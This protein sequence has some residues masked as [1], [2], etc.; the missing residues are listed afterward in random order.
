MKPSWTDAE[1]RETRKAGQ[2]PRR[3]PGSIR[4]RLLRAFLLIVIVAVVIL[5]FASIAVSLGSA[6]RQILDKLESVATLKQAEIELWL[7]GLRIDLKGMSRTVDMAAFLRPEPSGRA[8]PGEAPFEGLRDYMR[9]A[10]LFDEVFLMDGG[11]R[12]VA[13]TNPEQAGK[14]NKRQSYF[15]KGLEGP[16]FC[17]P[18]YYPPLDRM[19]IVASLPVTDGRGAVLGVLAG[20][21]SIGA[22]ERILSERAG[23][24]TS[25]ETYLIGANRVLLAESRPFDAERGMIARSEAANAAIGL[26]QDGS[27]LY[28]SHR[29]RA[30]AGAYRWMEGIQTALLVEQ[31][32]SEAFDPLYAIALVDSGIGL[33]TALAAFVASMLV[34]RNIA[35][36]LAE[37][38][39]TASR[40]AAG[41][42]DLPIP[43]ERDDE[44]GALASAFG[45]MA[46][47]LRKTIGGL[48]LRIE[49]RTADLEHHLGYLV[50]AS[51]VVQAISSILDPVEL[52]GRAVDMIGELFGLYHVSVY[53]LDPSGGRAE[54]RAGSGEAGKRIVEA[55]LSLD[56][57]GTSP[58]GRCLT[59]GEANVT[60]DL[61]LDPLYVPPP[62]LPLAR[63]EAALPLVARGETIGVL[64]ALSDRESAFG[65]DLMGVLRLLAA[66]VATALHNA[67]LFIVARD[68]KAEAE[69]ANRLK[70]D[71]LSCMSHE[72]R[73]PLNAVIN[74]A[75]LL[76]NETEGPVSPE[77]RNM[78][79]RIEGAGTH[80]LGLI[81]NIL[82]MAKIES[83]RLEIAPIELD[84]RE[85]AL[86]VAATASAL[87]K[88]KPVRLL[89]DM[90]ADLP[91]VFADRT[92]VKQVLLN[93]LSN[94]AKF[95]DE[96]SL[97]IRARDGQPGK[98]D[99]GPD[100]KW[101]TVS[102]EDTGIG[103]RPESIPKLF[104][105]FVQLEDTKARNA[106]GTGLGLSIC[107]RLI[108]MHGGSIWVE[109]ELGVGSRFSFT[110]PRMVGER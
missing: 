85:L 26:G 4:A 105:E 66:Q 94:A 16:S 86:E 32:Q 88:D 65:E 109:S 95:T 70:S 100:G 18:F 82:D 104:S 8:G 43:P 48:E 50:A 101:V 19:E 73:T 54:Y 57:P 11:G 93:L 83:G 72:L 90:P 38:A 67:E 60:Q 30:V 6:R 92:R 9:E 56:V 37:L 102:V 7:D 97:T 15:T 51:S 53:L 12:V 89:Q 96:G 46:V 45:S 31:D 25:G 87:V 63:S 61:G 103:L 99:R 47:R 64:D 69:K 42:L 35:T 36:P 98:G 55:G 3:G 29:S 23:L 44:V 62:Q 52:I 84:L 58:V 71:F 27:G 80:L 41:D 68:A 1:G 81:N 28:Q 10:G 40:I 79:E 17:Q 24:G 21:A 106:G 33:A 107:K 14:I 75:Y 22:L 77:Q 34:A 5:T 13:S 110:L 76:N 91:H 59:L 49:E 2:R 108:E 39:H 74:F 20:R 78:L